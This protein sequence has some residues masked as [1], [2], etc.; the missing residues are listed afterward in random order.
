VSARLVSVAAAV[1]MVFAAVLGVG[2]ARGA[3]DAPALAVGGIGT[4][5]DRAPADFAGSAAC[6]G[7]HAA[8]TKAWLGSHHAMAMALATPETVKGDFGDVTIESHG[9]TARFFRDGPR[10]MVE[11]DGKDGAKGVF[12]VSYSFGI[13]PLQQY[14]VTFLD[15]RIQA[16]PF[17]WDTRPKDQG[18]QRWFHLYPDRAVPSADPLHWTG[19]MQNWNYMC[20]EC[21]VTGFAKGYDA[22]ANHFDSRF[23]EVSVGC[24]GCHGA[25]APH[26][27]WAQAGADPRAP[28]KGFAAAA[29]TRA[30]ADWTIDPKTGS[31]AHGVAR[32]DGDEVETC[33]RCHARRGTLSE[34]WQPGRPLAATHLPALLTGEL[35]EDDGQMKD[36]VFNDH[37]FKQSLMYAKGVECSDC[38]DP[39]A[40]T[41]KAE[42]AAVCGQCHA[43]EKFAVVSHTGH[44]PGPGAPDCVSCHMPARTYMVVDRRHDHSFRIPRPDLTLTL[45]TPNACADCH[46]DKSAS[47]AS[48][49]VARWHGPTR[50]GHQTFADAFRTA[51]AGDPAARDM[52]IALAAQP[53]VPAVARATALSE[54]QRFP[55]IA[56]DDATTAALRDTDPLVRVAALRG[57]ASFPPDQRWRLASGLLAD[58]VLAV[59]VEAASLLADQNPAVLPATDRAKLEAAFAE[60]EATQRLNA[61]RPEGRSNLGGFLMRRGKAAEAEAEFLA[62]LKL[63]PRAAPIA[64]NLA[65]LYRAT[66]R[67]PAAEQMLRQAVQLSPDAAAPRHALGL[68]LVRQKR[69]AEALEQL[70]RAAALAPEEPRF[71][72]VYAV[73]LQSTG[74]PA[75]AHTVVTEA[76]K[77]N[78]YDQGLVTLGLQDALRGQDA[79]RAAPLAK[80]LA[81]LTPD[82][83]QIARLSKQ[84]GNR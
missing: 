71:A 65:D 60:Y 25:G 57:L 80:T 70:G 35:F 77:R 17:A 9:S 36:E 7:C 73:A 69:Y 84:L 24:E 13:S 67:D 18:G 29:A 28:L 39:H 16:L 3:K 72:Y 64:V 10:F 6:A 21:H 37:S 46:A 51:R 82:D 75:E 32:P 23:S 76:L 2:V 59:R 11:T 74:K 42:G 79:A 34:D 40:L 41:L 68:T 19:A 14:L 8:E 55:A 61:D 26:V 33:A 83:P 56:T 27:A 30:P 54:L 47:W 66:G 45:G 38:H 49:A 48:E 62:G 15:G 81:A 20:A 50:K 52:L 5:T 4:R 63:E 31:P 44:Q 22:V 12:E 1:A 58:P 78:P 53:A 43:P